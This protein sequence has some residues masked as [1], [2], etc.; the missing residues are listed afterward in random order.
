MSKDLES[1]DLDALQLDEDPEENWEVEDDWEDDDFVDIDLDSGRTSEEDPDDIFERP[2]RP[3][4][5]VEKVA[6]VIVA[7]RR[8]AVL[9]AGILEVRVAVVSPA[10][11]PT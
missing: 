6:D 2:E 11:R 1:K 8:R 5:K 3:V 10:A 4:R 7:I 9:T